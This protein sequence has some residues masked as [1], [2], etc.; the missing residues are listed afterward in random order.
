MV[1]RQ[2]GREV[3]QKRAGV[4]GGSVSVRAEVEGRKRK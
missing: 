3:D 2:R 4:E 1:G